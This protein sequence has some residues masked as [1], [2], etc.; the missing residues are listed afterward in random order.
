[1]DTRA[2]SDSQVPAAWLQGK[3]RRPRMRRKAGL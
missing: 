3:P 1:M 2:N